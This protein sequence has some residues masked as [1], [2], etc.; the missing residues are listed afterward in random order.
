[1]QRKVKYL[2]VAFLTIT[3]KLA[4]SQPG[5]ADYQPL[6]DT[7]AFFLLKQQAQQNIF[8]VRNIVIEG[9][10]K[11]RQS[12]IL[13][14]LP[15]K[16]G[17]VYQLSELVKEFEVA[18]RQ[19]MN[20]VLFH[21]VVVALKSFQGNDVDILVQ[22]KERWYLFPVPYFKIVDRNINQWLV[23]QHASLTRVNYGLKVIYNN[24]T[25]RNDKLNLYIM[26]GY[27]RQVSLNY[28]RPYIDKNMKWGLNIG[29]GLGKNREV[30]YNTINNKQVFFKDTN[31]FVRSFF[32]AMAE[33]T[34][35]PAIKTRHRFGIAYTVE[36][37]TDTIVALNPSYLTKGRD[38][39]A[40]PEIYYQATYFDVDYI[41][42]P[43][44]GYIAEV[45]FVKK[46]FNSVIN[47]WQFNAKVSGSWEIAN[48]TYFGA[49]ASGSLK[50]PFNQPY[51]HQRL[52]GY[53]DFFMQGYEY[54]VVDGVAGGYVKAILSRELI[55]LNFRVARKKNEIPYSIPF[56]VYGKVYG[57]AGYMY[58]PT[59][60]E[61]N[62]LSNRMLYSAGFGIDVITHYDFTIK[63]EWSFNQLGQ[64]GLYLHRKS[65]F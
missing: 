18:R 27:T 10:K 1:M 55:N 28:D 24:V 26:S 25:G 50:L 22:V 17:D 23:E 53:S 34:Y 45:Y 3:T 31:N 52:L 35:R 19:L 20:L 11:T 32:R 46:G 60:G 15:F 29:M 16:S 64:N 7:S 2:I 33:A 44:K 13:R 39:I 36:H 56:R 41:P 37:I 40:Y 47:M 65:Y 59:P 43:L 49:R 6:P 8:T 57:N 63:L 9:N 12:V 21:E 14:E 48:K 38:K 54:Y 58:H 62:T 61:D 51:I 30:N 5:L 4:N 42:Y